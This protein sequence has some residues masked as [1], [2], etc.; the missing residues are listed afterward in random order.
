MEER[1]VEIL[2]QERDE[3]YYELVYDANSKTYRVPIPF[4]NYVDFIKSM[5]NLEQWKSSKPTQTLRVAILD[6]GLMSEHPILKPLIDQSE[7]FTVEQEGIED[8]NGHGTLVSLILAVGLISKFDIRLLNGK[9]LNRE[10]KG[11]EKNFI[12]GIRW[13]IRD[14]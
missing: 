5:H 8:Q 2:G 12:E 10:G 11:L 1:I 13:A 3:D 14:S 4:W 7:D 6:T 9:V